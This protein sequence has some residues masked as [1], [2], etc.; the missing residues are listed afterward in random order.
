MEESNGVF[1]VPAVADNATLSDGPG[2]CPRLLIS[3]PSMDNLGWTPDCVG[4]GPSPGPALTPGGLVF[5]S[6]WA[7]PPIGPPQPP[8][9]VSI[10][11]ES[12]PL[13]GDDLVF[14][15]TLMGVP[16]TS[17]IDTSDLGCFIFFEDGDPTCAS[18]SDG[19]RLHCMNVLGEILHRAHA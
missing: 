4:P 18:C 8:K 11:L 3:N 9:T 6:A 10:T 13:S 16:P 15:S 1:A 2:A 17:A 19:V 14:S 7:C 12:A 5:T